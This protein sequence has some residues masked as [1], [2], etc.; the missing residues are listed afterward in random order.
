[1]TIIMITMKNNYSFYSE[2]NKTFWI[3]ITLCW[4]FHT[5][6]M[7]CD[8]RFNENE[9]KRKR[10]LSVQ[11]K[12]KYDLVYKET[13]RLSYSIVRLDDSVQFFAYVSIGMTFF[14]I[15]GARN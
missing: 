15:K 2:K 14:I 3:L 5:I 1:M 12:L 13:C 6:D 11:S 4:K 7:Q 9:G 8:K 10:I